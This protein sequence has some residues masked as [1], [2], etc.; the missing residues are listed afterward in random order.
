MQQSSAS[1]QQT[2]FA[3]LFVNRSVGMEFFV[4]DSEKLSYILGCAMWTVYILYQHD[5]LGAT[6]KPK[7]LQYIRTIIKLKFFEVL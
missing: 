6:M 1:G 4:I 2:L 5:V 7:Y 3:S